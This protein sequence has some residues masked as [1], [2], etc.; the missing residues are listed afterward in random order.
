MRSDTL[1]DAIGQVR[2]DYIIDAQDT[3]T[4]NGCHYGRGRPLPQW[5]VC[6]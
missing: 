2:D 6:S 4:N 3:S 5:F 1:Q